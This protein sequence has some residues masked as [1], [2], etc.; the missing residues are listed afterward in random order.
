MTMPYEGDPSGTDRRPIDEI[1]DFAIQAM[2]S[3]ESDEMTDSQIIKATKGFA[4]RLH[5]YALS[6]AVQP[7]EA[8]IL[9]L[10]E[11]AE[12]AA[13]ELMHAGLDAS[14]E[15]KKPIHPDTVKR[16]Q[17]ILNYTVD[18][19]PRLMLPAQQKKSRRKAIQ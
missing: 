14:A 9:D 4:G 18:P 8:A 2:Q 6:N 1:G 17:R 10:T 3:W 15:A 16:I 11:E 7:P 5:S 19:E 12:D 13:R